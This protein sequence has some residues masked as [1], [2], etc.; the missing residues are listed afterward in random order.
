MLSEEK[1]RSVPN[2]QQFKHLSPFVLNGF[3]R[4]DGR[5]QNSNLPFESMHPMILP[6]KH[7]VT[8]MLIRLYH[9]REGHSGTSHVLN[10]MRKSFWILP[11]R[12]AVRRVLH[13]C[14]K[15]RLCSTGVG[16]Q[17]M[18]NLPEAR[19]TAGRPPFSATGVDLTGPLNVKQGR[20][21][22]KCYVVVLTCMATRAVHLDIAQSLEAS[23]FIQAFRRVTCKWTTPKFMFSDNGT[24]FKGAE[25]ELNDG[26]IVT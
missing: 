3:M 21:A 25:R 10:C 4:M 26:I 17:R 12:A 2:L 23:A 14:F 18:A 8:D 15:C 9:E 22:V 11:G 19:M 24:N 20:N 16:A 13:A 7:S 5:L 6:T 1:L